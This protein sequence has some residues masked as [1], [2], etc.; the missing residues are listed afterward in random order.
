MAAGKAAEA[1]RRELVVRLKRIEGQ[2]RGIQSMIEA[3]Q[4]CEAIAQQFSAARKALDRAFYELLACAL[5]HPQFAARAD[6]AQS[7][8]IQRIARTLAKFA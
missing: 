4:D 2:L 5:E 7:D 1:A 3:G 6:E 8:R